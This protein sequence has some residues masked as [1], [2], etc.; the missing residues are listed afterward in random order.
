MGDPVVNTDKGIRPAWL[1]DEE[2]FPIEPPPTISK[3]TAGSLWLTFNFLDIPNLI[4]NGFIC[5]RWVYTFLNP[6][7]KVKVP[8]NGIVRKTRT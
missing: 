5:R 2:C 4:Q 3:N 1:G 6:G 7:A 8:D